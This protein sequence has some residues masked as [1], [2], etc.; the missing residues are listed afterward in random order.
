M[1]I[2]TNNDV[3]LSE[4]QV[5]NY[6]L[7]QIETYNDS[8]KWVITD[9]DGTTAILLKDVQGN[10]SYLYEDGEQTSTY[11]IHQETSEEDNEDCNGDG[12]LRSLGIFKITHYCSCSICCGKN[13][14]KFTASGTVPTLNR[15]IATDPNTIATG[16]KVIINGKEYIAED[17]GSAIKGNIIDIYVA[18]HAE[19]KQL[20]VKYAEIFIKM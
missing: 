8:G 17:T 3:T 2:A 19:A 10:V 5:V 14:G 7:P 18:S 15:T 9:K 12:R 1:T 13:G 11:P 6:S 4:N 20:G 16:S